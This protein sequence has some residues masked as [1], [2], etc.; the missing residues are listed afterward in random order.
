[1]LQCDYIII[2]DI[3]TNFFILFNI[4]FEKLHV[5]NMLITVS[6]AIIKKKWSGWRKIMIFFFIYKY[7]DFI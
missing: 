6:R 3:S 1:M 5:S 7:Y 4:T 2:P